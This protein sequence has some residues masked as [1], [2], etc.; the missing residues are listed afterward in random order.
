MGMATG[1]MLGLATGAL[2]GA[3]IAAMERPRVVVAPRGG[4]AG[5]PV[6]ENNRTVVNN[7]NV[8]PNVNNLNAR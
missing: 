7:V 8:H 3:E 1:A 4:F 5:R 2:I 6:I